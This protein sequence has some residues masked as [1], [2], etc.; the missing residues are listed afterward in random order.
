MD[1][2]LRRLEAM[3]IVA[4]RDHLLLV[5]GT[6]DVIVPDGDITASISAA[7]QGTGDHAYIDVHTA[8]APNALLRQAGAI[9][10]GKTVT[11]ELAVFSPGKTRNP[12]DPRRTPGGSSSGSAAAVAAGT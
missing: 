6:G 9:L 11:T 1:R 7:V 10:L 4:D 3:L 5:S 8:I 2:A 12:H